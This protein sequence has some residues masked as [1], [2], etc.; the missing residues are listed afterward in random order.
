MLYRCN[1]RCYIDINIDILSIQL[2][3]YDWNILELSSIFYLKKQS[4]ILRLCFIFRCHSKCPSINTSIFHSIYSISNKFVHAYP[5]SHRLSYYKHIVQL[6]PE[7]F[8]QLLPPPP[9][10]IFKYFNERL[11][12]A[13]LAKH[14]LMA[15]RS[16]CNP[17]VVGGLIEAATDL[18]NLLKINVLVQSFLHLGC[19]SFTHIFAILRKFQAV[20]KVSLPAKTVHSFRR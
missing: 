18:D 3:I 19:K 17:E 11:P 15:M 16:R 12:G 2:S 8:A 1:Y 9:D 5:A 7:S 13:K 14:L 4:N 6:V 10:P 20:L